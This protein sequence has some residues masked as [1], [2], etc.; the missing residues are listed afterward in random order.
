MRTLLLALALASSTLAAPTVAD[1][2]GGYGMERPTPAALEVTQWKQ[3]TFVV[4][5]SADTPAANASWRRLAPDTYGNTTMITAGPDT[6]DSRT[7]TLV[8]P[9]GTRVVST[10]K[11]VFLR[12]GAAGPVRQALVIE[13]LGERRYTVGFEGKRPD[14]RFLS[15]RNDGRTAI[16]VGG[17]AFVVSNIYGVTRLLRG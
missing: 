10:K 12:R 9:S 17:E 3:R 7:L 11:T 2:C 15:V 14:A 13:G 16:E 5:A 8:G 4:I 6:D 1:A